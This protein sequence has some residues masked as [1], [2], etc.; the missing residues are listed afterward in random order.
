MKKKSPGL[1]LI[2]LF[3]VFLAFVLFNPGK[4]FIK[5]VLLEEFLERNFEPV[6][7]IFHGEEIKPGTLKHYSLIWKDTGIWL[8]RTILSE[9]IQQENVL[10]TI[11][12]WSGNNENVL[13]ETLSGKFDQKVEELA[14]ILSQSPKQ[15]YIRWNPD[16]EVPVSEFPWQYQ[17]P[18][19]YIKSFNYFASKF[20]RL[21]PRVKIVWGPSGYPGDTEYW[22]GS[23]N[24]DLLSITLGSIS[25]KKAVNY[26]FSDQNPAELLRQKLHRMRFMNKA[27]I[28][29]GSEKINPSNFRGKWIG[30]IDSLFF[31][32]RKNIYPPADFAVTDRPKLFARKELKLGVYDPAKLLI[33]EPGI[34]TEHIFTDLGEVQNGLFEKK[35]TEITARKHD[36]IVTM[37]PWRDT[38]GRADPDPL[39]HLLAG[40]YD[41][42]ISRLFKV[43]Y[44]TNQTVYLRFAHEM[45]IPIHRYPWQSQDPLTYI[46]AFRYFM[47]SDTKRAKN[48]R[49]VWGPA[50]DRGSVDWWPGNDVVDF[51]SI[52]IYGLPDKNIEDHKKQEAFSTIFRRKVYRMRFLDKPIFITEFGVKGPEQYQKIWLEDAAGILRENKQVFGASYFNLH[53]NPKAWGKIEAPDWSISRKTFGYFYRRLP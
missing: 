32:Y 3:L 8:N 53:D 20:K 50:G 4:R 11:E 13:E 1:L 28:I 22:P 51:I 10:L 35:F 46:R 9:K 14:K 52:A 37:E 34:T 2:A 29:L 47:Q 36:V 6:T 24:V 25:E 7:G 49:K 26:P 39:N 44:Q 21:A 31:K 42:E 19:L 15:I 48:I 38:T 41:Q 27:V 40:R 5:S 23:E 17:S 12:T 33:N 16:M 43:L 45:E 18:E 30:Q